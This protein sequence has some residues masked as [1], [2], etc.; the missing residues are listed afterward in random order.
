MFSDLG[1]Q[2]DFI[3]RPRSVHINYALV[4]ASSP[5]SCASSERFDVSSVNQNIN[6]AQTRADCRLFDR[7]FLKLFERVAAV[8]NDVRAIE[9]AQLFDQRKQAFR[10]RER[11]AAQNAYAVALEFRIKQVFC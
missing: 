3:A 8:T 2:H 9:F 5:Q 10:L 4:A 11:L 7:F 6:L 1:K